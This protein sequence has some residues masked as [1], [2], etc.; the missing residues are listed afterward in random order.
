MTTRSQSW[1]SLTLFFRTVPDNAQY[2]DIKNLSEDD[3]SEL[4]TLCGKK[5]LA[6]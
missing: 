3:E 6:K 2:S 5:K 1:N 4:F